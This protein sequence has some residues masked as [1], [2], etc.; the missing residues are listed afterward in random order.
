MGS[1]TVAQAGWSPAAMGEPMT[2]AAVGWPLRVAPEVTAAAAPRSQTN[3]TPRSQSNVSC[4]AQHAAY[5]KRPAAIPCTKQQRADRPLGRSAR[6]DSNC[7]PNGIA[8]LFPEGQ[9][10]GESP[11]ERRIAGLFLCNVKELKVSAPK[12]PAVETM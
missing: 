2:V 5:P 11:P 1:P 6:C 7:V 8:T 3:V 12:A 4:S 9:P 10:P